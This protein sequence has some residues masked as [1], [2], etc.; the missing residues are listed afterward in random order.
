MRRFGENLQG[1]PKYA[2]ILEKR[3]KPPGQHGGKMRRGRVGAYGERLLEKQKLKAIY[4][5]SESQMRRYMREAVR[6]S[7]PTGTNL[8]Q[9]LEL[10]LDAVVFRMGIAP[11]IWAARQVVG[12]GHILVDGK[13]VDIPSYLVRPGE[14][15]SVSGKFRDNE[16]LRSWLETRA[17]AMM[18]P[19]LELDQQSLS[20]RMTRLP[21]REEIPVNINDNL[22]IEFYAR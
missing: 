4:D 9:I 15:I 8:L 1:T 13:R 14:E 20:G 3:G 2:R 18:P 17:P 22:I 19:Y 12:H 6:R 16:Q 5:L 11:T 7:G 21:D 10:R